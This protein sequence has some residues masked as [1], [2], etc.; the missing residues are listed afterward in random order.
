MEFKRDS[1]GKFHAT[2]MAPKYI[3][4]ELRKAVRR[5]LVM[6]GRAKGLDDLRIPPANHLERL[7]GDL[8]G[9]HSIR[10]NSQWRI[11]FIWTEKGAVNVDL[12][13]YH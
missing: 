4:S 1:L 11:I 10:V 2:G 6:L 3:P 13:D 9:Y 8:A 12:V 7:K 5:K